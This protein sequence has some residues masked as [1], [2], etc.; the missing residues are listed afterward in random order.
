MKQ[1]L[2]KI[3]CCTAAA[4]VVLAAALATQVDTASASASTPE[5]AG[6]FTLPSFVLDQKINVLSLDEAVA[7]G[8][9]DS[10]VVDAL[11]AD[12]K[13]DAIVTFEQPLN[14]NTL[15]ELSEKQAIEE[16]GDGADVVSAYRY[17]P[18]SFVRFTS[19]QALL[20]MVNADSVTGV[21]FN[22]TLVAS[23]TS[24]LP[25]I[26]QPE[27]AARGFTGSGTYV[28]VLDSGVDYTHPAFGCSAP[29]VP[30]TCRVS[31]YYEFGDQD[32][33]LDDNVR[34]GTNV[35]GIV[36]SVAPGARIIAMD[37]FRGKG[38]YTDDQIAAINKL[39]ALKASGVNVVA[40]NMSLESAETYAKSAC[41]QDP[42]APVFA[43][44]RQWG[45]LPVVSAGND[46]YGLKL[47]KP[48]RSGVSNPACVPGAMRVGAV[49]AGPFA[50]QIAKCTT[51]RADVPVCFSQSGK[52]LTM[53]APGLEITAAGIT[54][55]GTSQAAPH[56]AGAVAVLAQAKY[57]A[58]QYR[59]AEAQ[60]I[61]NA[62]SGSGPSI[63]DK[64]SGI[65]RR[66]L[67]VSA[68]VD[69]LLGGGTPTPTPPTTGLVKP[70]RYVGTTSQNE[71]I[72]FEISKDGRTI[73]SIRFTRNES[74]QPADGPSLYGNWW[75]P[76]A[77]I[78]SD[79]RFSSVWSGGTTAGG[80][81][82]SRIDGRMDSLGN[83]SGSFSVSETFPSNGTVFQCSSGNVLWTARLS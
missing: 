63:Y 23:G 2:T 28:A 35:A 18:V 21:R 25:L 19:D 8:R 81:A 74:C 56:V 51:K 62:L 26:R 7:A 69:A 68:A 27:A 32:G 43:T 33:Q 46:A 4:V 13:V 47:D 24:S 45:I 42:L 55:S 40:L 77:T 75:M 67:D 3:S 57:G 10:R 82:N 58:G 15:G 65:T 6:A 11:H 72:S 36:A 14:A 44:A 34:H 48:F 54:M 29:A 20:G 12:G 73:T 17:L 76:N 16:A 60:L 49:S 9:L 1:L 83:A 30:S 53:L 78:G 66:R 5:G 79:S 80:S 50:A 59:A 31:H 70:G 64:R 39:F 37:V 71:P 52:L 38:S 41:S 22:G 61:Q